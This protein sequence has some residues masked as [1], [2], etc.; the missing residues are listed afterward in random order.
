MENTN[1]FGRSEN[2]ALNSKTF[3][4]FVGVMYEE[5]MT[6]QG[7]VI[8]TA[9]LLVLV[10]VSAALAWL[11]ISHDAGLNDFPG[12][13]GFVMLGAFL[14]GLLTTLDQR[15]APLTAPLYAVLEGSV[16]GG[17]SA[18]FE[19]YYPGIVFPSVALTFGTLLSLLVISGEWGFQ[20]TGAF[21][22]GVIAAIMSILLVH[23]VNLMLWL[24]GLGGIALLNE[25]GVIGILFSL[26][27]VFIAALNLVLDFELI[28]AGTRAGAPK[29]MEWYAAYSLM[30]TL[31]WLYWEV[32]K[33]LIQL[34]ASRDDD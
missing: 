11:S 32:L 9:I 18:V 5:P 25:G 2:W 10:V 17:I 22:R 4:K 27:V 31:I 29:Y 14:V 20:V 23:V 13:L 16:L 6:I 21:R 33:L 24:V 3:G 26:F 1:Q 7:V 8:K 19:A 34:A 28:E 12:W 15:L 30:V